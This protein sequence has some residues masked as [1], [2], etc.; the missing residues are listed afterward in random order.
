ML[1]SSDNLVGQVTPAKPMRRKSFFAVHTLARQKKFFFVVDTLASV[2][3]LTLQR[4][5]RLN[6][7]WARTLHLVWL[8][9][10]RR[11]TEE[12]QRNTEEI[13]RNT[14]K[15]KNWQTQPHLSEN[16]ALGL[17]HSML[18]LRWTGPDTLVLEKWNSRVKDLSNFLQ[19]PWWWGWAG[20]ICV[21]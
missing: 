11:N 1:Y 18:I 5:S 6:L 3:N 17:A 7:T 15:Y 10:C 13:Q 21:G 8:T 20:Q 4:I 14:E 12:I 19:I 9:P 2:M 16:I